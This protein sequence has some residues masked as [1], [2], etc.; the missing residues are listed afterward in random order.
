MRR[1]MVLNRK[2]AVFYSR[3]MSMLR[4]FFTHQTASGLHYMVSS[5]EVERASVW[6]KDY[7]AVCMLSMIKFMGIV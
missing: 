2:L 3:G 1:P 7:K 5:G 4:V 6:E